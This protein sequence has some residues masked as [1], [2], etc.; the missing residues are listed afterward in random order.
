MSCNNIVVIQHIR[1]K[2]DNHM[3]FLIAFNNQLYNH[4]G[5]GRRSTCLRDICSITVLNVL[6]IYKYVLFFIKTK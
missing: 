4:T 5:C 3:I 2:I 1:S 6:Y